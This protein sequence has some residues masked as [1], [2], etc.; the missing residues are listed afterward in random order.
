MTSS[1]LLSFKL[2]S[3]L[4]TMDSRPCVSG[5]A[6]RTHPK[7][8]PTNLIFDHLL[9]TP[10]LVHFKCAV[11]YRP[12]ALEQT[13]GHESLSRP[14]TMTC[15]FFLAWILSPNPN[16]KIHASR[17]TKQCNKVWGGSTNDV[18]H[19]ITSNDEKLQVTSRYQQ[20][21]DW[22]ML[23]SAQATKRP[24]KRITW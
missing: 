20:R 13:S 7:P 4:L 12:L 8:S 14:Q 22:I 2:K 18:Q 21:N 3:H 19:C 17:N 1:H 9:P 10:A 24:L 16:I 15:I 5:R 23:T 11:S 6:E